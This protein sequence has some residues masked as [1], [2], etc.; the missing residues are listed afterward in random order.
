MVKR[1]KMRLA[2]LITVSALLLI[3]TAC[4]GGSGSN[5]ASQGGQA[6][7]G[8]SGQGSASVGGNE[9]ANAGAEEQK[10]SFSGIVP[11]YT[12]PTGNT[13]YILSAGLSNLINQDSSILPDV[14]L[15]TET[16]SGDNGTLEGLFKRYEQ[17]RPAFSTN[18]SSIVSLAY[19]GQYDVLPGEHKEIRAVATL[20]INPVH[21]V[22][23]KNSSIQSYAD[24][25][26]KKV[27]GFAPGIGPYYLVSSLL[28]EH[29]GVDIS[30]IENIPLSNEDRI[31][32]LVD[33]SV[34]AAFLLG[35]PPSPLVTELARTTDIRLIPL[36]QTVVEE[37]TKNHPYYT[38]AVAAGGTYPGNDVDVYLPSI[39]VMMVTH[40]DT[41]DDIVYQL[42][43]TLIENPDKVKE[44]HPS[45]NITLDNATIGT[46]VPFHPGAKQYYEENGVTVE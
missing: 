42:L 39:R 44:M 23:K 11:I 17:G 30:E 18:T 1:S 40:E 25:K 35:A 36:D 38:S 28:S 27:A 19:Q 15:S 16:T 2:L 9:S 20:G 26:G 46:D 7:S 5:G 8:G 22:V 14:R 4:G 45:F 41:P 43:K 34:D 21:L 6:S 32:S 3:L 13:L 12:P 31:S 29:F 37:F 24:L 33:G 10:S